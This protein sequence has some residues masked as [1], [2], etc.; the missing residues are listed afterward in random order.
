LRVRFAISSFR[1][2]AAK[3]Y[4]ARQVVKAGERAGRSVTGT[5]FAIEV[6]EG[7]QIRA[8]VKPPDGEKL[9]RRALVQR[10]GP[11]VTVLA[12]FPSPG[13][14]FVQVFSKRADE[15]GPYWRCASFVFDTTG[16]TARTF[17]KTYGTY[18]RLGA[19]LVSPLY[20]P[21]AADRATTFR[22]RVPGASEVNLVIDKRWQKLQPVA[23]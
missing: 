15:D 13:R 3:R 10:D 14:W 11:R 2:F 7:V 18:Q 9:D 17:P 19:S 6:P 20:L 8:G 12:T 22:I 16:G 23:G 4:G 21:I 1:A 5:Q